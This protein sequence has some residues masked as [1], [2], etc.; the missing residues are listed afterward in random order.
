[1]R[2]NEVS[3]NFTPVAGQILYLQPKRDKAELGQNIYTAS[4]GETMY[5]ISQKFAIKVRKL[6]E[7][8]R[9]EEGEEPVAGQKLWLRTMKPV[10]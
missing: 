2:Y 6:Y 10:N 5:A 4:E 3:S 7:Y 9:M 1:L 8:N